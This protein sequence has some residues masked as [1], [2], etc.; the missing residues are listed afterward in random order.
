M[1][2]N[3][4]KFLRLR[5]DAVIPHKNKEGDIGLDIHCVSSKEFRYDKKREKWCFDLIPFTPHLFDLGFSTEF[6]VEY[7]V[8]LK[9]RSGLA[10][11]GV[12]LSAGVID[13][14]YRNEWMVCLTNISTQVYRVYENDRIAQAIIIPNLNIYWKKVNQLNK[15]ER[16]KFGFGTS[17]R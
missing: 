15:S 11:K 9:D 14:G 3:T 5:K 1:P 12:C 8:L 17:G 10:S 4:F 16:G 13:S 6:P 7:G 2:N